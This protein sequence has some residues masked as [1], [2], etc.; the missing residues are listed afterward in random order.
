MPGSINLNLHEF[1]EGAQEVLPPMAYDYY[2]SGAN[3]EITLK[4]NCEAYRRLKLAPR[5]L[6]DVSTRHL[7]AKIFGDQ[8][9]MPVLIAPTAMQRMAHPDGEVAMVRAAGKAGTI[10]VLSTLSTASIEE[11]T[12]AATG[13]VWF[14][15]YVYKDRD[16]TASLV[17]RAEKA[18]CT[19]IVLTVDSPHLGR[20]E[21][22]VR[23][24]FRLP[25]GLCLANLSTA[26][27]A[28]FPKDVGDSGL[29]A[30]IASLYDTALTWSDLK[31]LKSI[32]KL[33]LLVKGILRVDDARR[34]IRYGAEGIIVSNHGGRQLDTVPATIDVLPAIVDACRGR[35]EVLVDGGV[36][37]GTD[38]L[39]AL[40]FGAR[41]VL[42]GR[43]ALWGLAVGGE[44][45]VTAILELLRQE[46]DLALMLSGCPDVSK[47][48]RDLVYRPGI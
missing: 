33:P 32:T 18:G 14:Q 44:D 3:D 31:W 4:E 23:N 12:A 43:P 45:G 48:R 27:L 10:M 26:G 8:V 35:A 22:D 30:Y 9:S 11:V 21:R 13:P 41:A 46:L 37:R 39:K 47:V 29:A 42:I 15:L 19:A 7:Q 36:R 25:D 34:A 16:I 1:E 40:A 38:V 24:C 17:R 28:D 6:V 5:M 20:R 2:S